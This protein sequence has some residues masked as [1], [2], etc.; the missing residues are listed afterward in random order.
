MYL[1]FAKCPVSAINNVF[2]IT[3]IQKTTFAMRWWIFLALYG[4]FGWPISWRFKCVG[5]AL[6]QWKRSLCFS[7]PTQ[8]KNLH[9]LVAILAAMFIYLNTKSNVDKF[10]T[11]TVHLYT[12]VK[13]LIECG[14]INHVGCDQQSAHI[15][16]SVCFCVLSHHLEGQ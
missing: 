4:H 3:S 1:C 15:P 5:I 14:E 8:I 2:W 9:S 11:L 12:I 10:S 13:C 6:G 7:H 16:W